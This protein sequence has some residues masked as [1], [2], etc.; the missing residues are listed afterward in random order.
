MSVQGVRNISNRG[1][2]EY[3]KTKKGGK[4]LTVNLSNG[5]PSSRFESR[6]PLAEGYSLLRVS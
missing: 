1:N 6:F 5:C 3:Y 4:P 2:Y